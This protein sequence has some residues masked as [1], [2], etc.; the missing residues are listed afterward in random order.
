MGYSSPSRK[1][2]QEVLAAIQ[3]KVFHALK[4]KQNI[5]AAFALIFPAF[6]N[7]CLGGHYNKISINLCDLSVFFVLLRILFSNIYK[8][9]GDLYLCQKNV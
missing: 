5:A 3:T 6:D 1:R 4:L 8:Y 7:V 9:K 2:H